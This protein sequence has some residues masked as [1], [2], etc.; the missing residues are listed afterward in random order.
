MARTIVELNDS[1]ILVARDQD[2]L[3]RSPGI[4]VIGRDGIAL[5][6]EALKIARLDPRN[7]FNRF[8]SNLSQDRL[9][10]TTDHARHNA[11]LAF[12]HL[13]ALHEA[14]GKPDEL[15]FSVPGSFSTEQLALLLGL[16][17]ASPFSVIGMVDSA[18]AGAA[19][20]GV[21]GSFEHVD[22]HLHH[23]VVT[24]LDVSE[25]VERTAVKVL[26]GAGL[27][28]IHDR[29]AGFIADLFIRQ[30]RFDPLHHARTEQSLYDQIPRAL[31]ALQ[32]QAELLV[33]IQ[34]EQSRHQVRLLREPLV[35][36][37]SPIYGQILDA[38]D[39]ARGCLL[40]RRIAHLPAFTERLSNHLVLDE[41]AVF[42][43][44][45]QLP[46]SASS[47]EEGVS[48]VTRLRAAPPAAGT[49]TAAPPPA[50]P[51]PQRVTHLLI[52]HTAH[53]LSAAPVY[54]DAKAG[55]RPERSA[56]TLCSAA[57]ADVGV[58]LTIEGGVTARS[59]GRTFTGT[60][61]LKA[62]EAV[63]FDGTGISLRAI[64]VVA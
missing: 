64:T 61:D 23:A 47:G 56:D 9:Q 43:G 36:A 11:D 44:C 17:E 38:L 33:D 51:R 41:T 4:A 62:G 55:L 59:E 39:S 32:T 2:I 5:G 25:H 22:L 3:V 63:E 15:V 6:A 10:H 29:C 35:A 45:L 57:L 26:D 60:V 14:A 28:E 7:T 40:S 20:S 31:A 8:W 30:A 37:L 48:F 49:G 52:N 18:V 34:F 50:P 54:L 12:A 46:L 42:R 19:G 1:E 27:A 58:R 13:L 24:S 16:A 21:R 53:A